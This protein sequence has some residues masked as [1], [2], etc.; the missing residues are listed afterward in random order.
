M[1]RLLTKDAC[2]GMPIQAS[3]VGGRIAAALGGRNAGMTPPLPC[4]STA[5]AAT[6]PPLPCVPAAFVAKPPPFLVDFQRGMSQA[7]LRWTAAGLRWGCCY[8]SGWLPA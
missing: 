8:R 7:V 4:V 6:T 3:G 5:F 2:A 1:N